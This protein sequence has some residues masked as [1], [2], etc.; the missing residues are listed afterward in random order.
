M[1]IKP[2]QRFLDGRFAFEPGQVYDIP[3]RKAYVANNGW[4]EEIADP[5]GAQIVVVTLEQMSPEAPRPA[6]EGV[7]LEVQ[8]VHHVVL[9][10]E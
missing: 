7:T 9:G 4:A 1:L 8:D 5:G 6:G 10:G 3:E 2:L